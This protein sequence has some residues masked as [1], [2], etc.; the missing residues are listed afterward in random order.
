MLKI[1]KDK[2]SII[3]DLFLIVFLVVFYV[4]LTTYNYPFSY[5]VDEGTDLIKRELVNAGYEL[6]RDIWSD[7]PPVYTWILVGW[8][9]LVGSS[10]VHARFLTILFS[11]FLAVCFRRIIHF[12]YGQS[13]SICAVIL[14]IFSNEYIRFSTVAMKAVPNLSLGLCSLLLLM[15]ASRQ[16]KGILKN[17]LCIL[18]GS[19]LGISMQLKLFIGLLIPVIFVYCSLEFGSQKE[20]RNSISSFSLKRLFRQAFNFEFISFSIGLIFWFL[21]LGFIGHSLQSDQLLIGHF[22]NQIYDRNL[23]IMRIIKLAKKENILLL[24]LSAS[25]F[26]LVILELVSKKRINIAT[27]LPI[28]WLLFAFIAFWNHIPIW[29]HY[30]LIFSIPSIWLSCYSLSFFYKILIAFSCRFLSV[31]DDYKQIKVSSNMTR[32]I[33]RLGLFAL[34]IM[35]NY[36][37]LISYLNFRQSAFNTNRV[38]HI[39]GSK[40]AIFVKD[41]TARVGFYRHKT[42]WIYT[43]MS[44]VAFYNGLLV[45]PEVAVATSKTVRDSKD[46]DDRLLMALEKYK[47]EQVLL[48][49]YYIYIMNPRLKK[50]LTEHYDRVLDSSKAHHYIIKTLAQRD[51]H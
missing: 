36:S 30:Y 18:S 35:S 16:K 27:I 11:C 32:F 46:Y 24:F 22:K 43:D 6:F 12:F 41:M 25:S 29:N 13:I 44:I 51:T 28:V 7:Q 31:L 37:S 23:N 40:K 1:F 34:I 15:V 14:L 33:Q 48:T 47:P 21:I 49:Y 38:A 20:K 50:Y 17:F 26:F 2:S 42:R 19:I 10:I 5:E 45:P 9:K 4:F 8:Q 39:S 3:V